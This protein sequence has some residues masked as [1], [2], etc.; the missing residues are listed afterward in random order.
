M[1]P[2]VSTDSGIDI[3]PSRIAIKLQEFAFSL[4]EMQAGQ[5]WLTFSKR[6]RVMSPGGIYDILGGAESVSQTGQEGAIA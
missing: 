5:D 2:V 6:Y 3:I 4:D 1:Q